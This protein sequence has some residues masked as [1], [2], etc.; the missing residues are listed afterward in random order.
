MTDFSQTRAEQPDIAELLGKLADILRGYGQVLTAFDGNV[1]ATL[2]AAVAREVLGKENAPV[3]ITTVDTAS[4]CTTDDPFSL[5]EQ[6]DLQTY[7]LPQTPANRGET[8][9]CQS[10]QS[11]RQAGMLQQARTLGVPYLAIADHTDTEHPQG[12]TDAP[13]SPPTVVTPLLE[14]GMNQAQVRVA[15]LIMGLTNWSQPAGSC[16][17]GH[18]HLCQARTP[19]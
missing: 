2:I 8:D 19:K 18:V 15:A 3:V 6:L 11:R 12:L 13:A 17:G 9:D 5:A 16:Q 1:S 10:C 14:A 4:G 7:P